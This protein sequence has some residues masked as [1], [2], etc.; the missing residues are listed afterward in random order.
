[1]E[2]IKTANSVEKWETNPD[3]SKTLKGYLSAEDLLDILIKKGILKSNDI[4]VT[5]QAKDL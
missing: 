2:Y 5:E 4:V 3:G 1:M